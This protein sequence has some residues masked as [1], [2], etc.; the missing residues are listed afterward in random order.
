MSLLRIGSLAALVLLGLSAS[1]AP[2]LAADIN[3]LCSRAIDAIMA[4]L[5]PQFERATG[6][7]V[8]LR[9][10]VGSIL[11]REIEA[12]AAFD[13][14][15]L[16]GAIDDLVKGGKITGTPAVL[17]RTGYGVAVRKGAPKPDIGTT[18]AFKRTLLNA[19]AVTFNKDGGSG[20]YFVG[21]LDRLGIA[22]EMK[23]KLMPSP[24]TALLVAS[25]QADLTVN[26]LTPIL[27]AP[28]IELVG[29]L[30]P[31]L[32]SHS[33]FV[34]GVSAAAKDAEA[35]TALVKFLTTP[36]ALAVFKKRGVEPVPP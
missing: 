6:H 31:E 3:L 17:G 32:Q 8:V 4:E 34:A 1:A 10:G 24:D 22:E 11:K 16:V 9:Y 29:P 19:R 30:P 27:R 13:A 26:G 5:V 21:L 18:E 12:G 36:A 14:A 2:A 28:G 35:A 7:K 33:V 15:I 25:G 20:T 23:P